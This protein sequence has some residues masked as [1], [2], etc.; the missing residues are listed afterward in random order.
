MVTLYF[1]GNTTST[2][3]LGCVLLT[4]HHTIVIDGGMP[5]DAGQIAELLQQHSRSRVD[6]WFFTH[7]HGDHIGAFL[8]F[9]ERYS[10]M[11]VGGVYHHFPSV[12]ERNT[13]GRRSE[14]E[15]AMWER[16][17]QLAAALN[18]SEIQRGDTFRF[19]EITISVLRV[20]DPRITAD[21]INNSSAVFRVDTPDR[22]V[23][24]LGDLGAEGGKA[25]Q[26]SCSADSLSADY[27]QMAHHGQGGVD[28]EFYAY[29]RPRCCLWPTPRWLWEND[30]GDGPGTGPWKTCETRRWMA[31]LGVTEH[32]VQKDGTAE[33]VLF[34]GE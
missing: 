1:L 21:F 12:E 22:S 18:G 24:I 6:A 34:E 30:N 16:F 13:Y 15:A 10:E 9:A 5:Q 29:I 32:I 4:E 17:E 2:Q 11:T 26:A 20:Y 8:A 7:P 19:D 25:L 23:L 3:M 33:I 27:T 31:E 14:A 28:R